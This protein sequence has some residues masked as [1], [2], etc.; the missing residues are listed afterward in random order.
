MTQVT[1]VVVYLL[2]NWLFS[3]WFGLF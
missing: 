3:V 1:G 2:H